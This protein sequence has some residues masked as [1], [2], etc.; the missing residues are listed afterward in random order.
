MR[1]SIFF[2]KVRE[3]ATTD[4]QLAESLLREAEGYASQVV[5]EHLVLCAVGG[6]ATSTTTT[7]PSD[8]CWRRNAA[9]RTATCICIWPRHISSSSALWGLPSAVSARLSPWRN[10]RMTWHVSANSSRHSRPTWRS[11]AKQRFWSLKRESLA[12]EHLKSN[13]G[14]SMDRLTCHNEEDTSQNTKSLDMLDILTEQ[15]LH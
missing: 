12:R 15:I 13:R 14:K 7:M 3:I 2:E 5:P 6:S 8:A 10:Q 4:P 9:P 1:Y 11:D